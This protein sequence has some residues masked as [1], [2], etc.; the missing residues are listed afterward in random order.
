MRR[1]ALRNHRDADTAADGSPAVVTYSRLSPRAERRWQD[2]DRAEPVFDAAE[3]PYLRAEPR[4][5][6]GPR[7][8]GYEQ[9]DPE[10]FT[11][12]PGRPPRRRAGRGI[13]L[14]GAVALAAG[15][16]LLAY[17]YGV[18]TSL[19]VPA[20]TT[21]PAN[22]VVAPEPSLTGGSA[23]VDTGDTIRR[24]PL[25]ERPLTDEP[26][27]AATKD[28]GAPPASSGTT[29]ALPPAEAAPAAPPPKPK[30]RPQPAAIQP[31]TGA[32]AAPEAPVPTAIGSDTPMDG[33]FAA[34]VGAQPAISAPV[35][36][37]IAPPRA[38]SA[39]A[40][41]QAPAAAAPATT[42]QGDGTDGLMANIEK[43][44][45]R[46]APAA[47]APAP[48]DSA[49][50]GQP[51]PLGPFAGAQP[52]PDP[53]DPNAAAVDQNGQPIPVGPRG[54]LLLPPAD[55]PGAPASGTGVQ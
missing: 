41:A 42:G 44:L 8:R 33:E 39:A 16:T 46:D 37:T 36:A 24:V 14:L 13:V 1:I 10:D 7:A 9:I 23:V 53:N 5:G 38:A 50:P 21:V 34:P 28:I 40:A 22:T 49:A 17:A 4:E 54:R 27:S 30:A 29:A 11:D 43:L 20:T 45:Q 12:E 25:G 19:D 32:A 6:R 15:G 51:A 31:A 35:P 52:L 3:V 55:I 26:A 18:A 48:A 2:D 47:T